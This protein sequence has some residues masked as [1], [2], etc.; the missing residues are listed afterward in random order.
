M[1]YYPA[2]ITQTIWVFKDSMVAKTSWALSVVLVGF[3]FD[4]FA[5]KEDFD[6][7]QCARGDGF[8]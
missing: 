6:C 2:P 7:V 5:D 4:V 8:D 1:N 3:A